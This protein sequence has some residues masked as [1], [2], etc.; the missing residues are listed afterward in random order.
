MNRTDR[1]YALVE[2]LRGVAPRLRSARWL[3]DR[4]SVSTR[5]IERDLLALQEAGVPIWAENGRTGGYTLDASATL[6]PASFTA[7]E[8]LALLVGLGRLQRG[9]FESAATTAMRKILAVMP[10]EE[11]RRAIVAA[12]RIHLLEPD[13]DRPTVVPELAASLRS[14]RVIRLAYR[15]RAGEA[16]SREVEPLGSIVK[17]DTWYLI[18]WCRLRDGVRA[19]RGDRIVSIELT[20]E[21]PPRRVL[22]PE[23]LDIPFGTLRPLVAELR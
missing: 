10:D 22:R 20:D 18:A 4:F 14:D 23:D 1:L 8:A 5:T 21:R 19:F 13:E 6:P 16:S 7:D 12:S 15:D 17:S 11:A 9:P 3:A 2:E